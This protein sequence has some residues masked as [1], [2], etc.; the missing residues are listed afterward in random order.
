MPLKLVNRKDAYDF[1]VPMKGEDEKTW[2]VFKLRRLAAE[3]VNRIEDKLL[4]NKPGTEEMGYMTGTGMRMKLEAAV[5]GW[6]N[7]FNEDGQ[8]SEFKTALLGGLPAWVQAY[9]I[10]HIDDENGLNRKKRE[11][12]EKN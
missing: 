11:E 5:V 2:P 1:K 9:L 8:P 6:S 4:V 10:E 12:H 3:E 7:V